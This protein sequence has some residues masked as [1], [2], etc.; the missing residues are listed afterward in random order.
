MQ[1]NNKNYCIILK[2]AA[3]YPFKAEQRARDTYTYNKTHLN[4]K[5][6]P[7]NTA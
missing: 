1:I 7:G 4:Q 5:R 2:V 3:I 6:Y